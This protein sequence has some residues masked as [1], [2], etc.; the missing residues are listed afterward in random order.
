VTF[1]QLGSASFTRAIPATP[2]AAEP[3]DIIGQPLIGVHNFAEINASLSY[4]TGVSQTN[5]AV[6]ATYLKVQQQL[7]TL[8]N[9][10]GFLAAQQM[11][12]TQLTVAYCNALVG[13]STASNTPRDTYFT[14]FSFAAPA[15]TA[16]STMGRSQIIEPLLKRLLAHEV[17]QTSGGT[18]KLINQADPALLRTE[19]N[20]LITRMT[21]CGGSCASDRTLTTVKAACSAAFGSAVMLVH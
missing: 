6:A 21:A 7:P 9:L 11:G 19:L 5:T 15:S 14:G 4:L 3:A 18:A 1:D 16:F 10:D 17:G 8:A 20:N 12:I 13:N 2:P